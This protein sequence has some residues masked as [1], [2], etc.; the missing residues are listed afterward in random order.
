[1]YLS[2]LP[3]SQSRASA[4]HTGTLS[5]PECFLQNELGL[6]VKMIQ[7]GHRQ[8]PCDQNPSRQVVLAGRPPGNDLEYIVGKVATSYAGLGQGE[9][10]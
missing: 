7:V 2:T 10:Q 1:M 9:G 4:A 3:T 6:Q 5:F 8:V